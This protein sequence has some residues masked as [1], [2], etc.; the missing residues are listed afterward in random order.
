MVLGLWWG[1]GSEAEPGYSGAVSRRVGEYAVWW[2]RRPYELARGVRDITVKDLL[3]NQKD[4]NSYPPNPC[5]CGD[6]IP[7]AR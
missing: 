1:W 7:G 4:Q 5:K 3:N 2:G 6:W